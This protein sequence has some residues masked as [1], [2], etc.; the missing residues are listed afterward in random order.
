MI[1]EK[2]KNIYPKNRDCDRISIKI[3]PI[4]IF[5]ISKD[6]NDSELGTLVQP[7]VN[8]SNNIENLPRDLNVTF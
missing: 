7:S 4:A 8:V 1:E 2:R 3:E 5:F 6:T